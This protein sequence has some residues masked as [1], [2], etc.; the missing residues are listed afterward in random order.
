MAEGH[1]HSLAYAEFFVCILRQLR[2]EA[3]AAQ[4]NAEKAIALSA[5]RDLT[6]FSFWTTCVRGWVIAEQGRSEVGIAQIREGLSAACAT[7]AEINRPYYLCLLAEACT[8][9]G[10]LDDGLSALTQALAAADEREE[11]SYEVE[12][13]R[14]KGELLL[15]AEQFQRIR[16]SELL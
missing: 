15:K 11:R 2:R 5:E 13:H 7:G 16:G 6:D 3:H 12:I 1:P 4:E 10:R 8:K 14:L 9:T